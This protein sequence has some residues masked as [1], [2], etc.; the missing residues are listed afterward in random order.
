[1]SKQLARMRFAAISK[2][3]GHW[4]VHLFSLSC[5]TVQPSKDFPRT[6]HNRRH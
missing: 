3:G 1:M 5:W 6:Q 2:E 4:P